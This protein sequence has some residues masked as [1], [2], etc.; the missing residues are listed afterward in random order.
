MKFLLNAVL[1]V[2]GLLATIIAPIEADEAN[3]A[4]PINIS[5]QKS[6]L[7]HQLRITKYPGDNKI[8]QFV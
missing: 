2:L 6:L 8:D 1:A 4:A 5:C 3:P 7:P